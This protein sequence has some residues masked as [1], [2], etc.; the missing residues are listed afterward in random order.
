[1]REILFRGKRKD[2]GE[3]VFGYFI[4]LSP[5]EVVIVTNNSY[6]GIEPETGS[7]YTGL[8]D[9]NGRRIFE[10][11]ILQFDYDGDNGEKMFEWYTVQ[12]LQ[13]GA[14]KASCTIG[15]NAGD[16]VLLEDLPISEMYIIG[17]KWE[18]LGE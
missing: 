18:V 14:F 3:W 6:V 4:K 13:N 1:M 9:K 15:D 17:K 7:E 8:T 16:I 10:G 11:D 5:K 12:E 2:N